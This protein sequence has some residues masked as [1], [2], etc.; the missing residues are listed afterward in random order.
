[1]KRDTLAFHRTFHRNFRHFSAIAATMLIRIRTNVGTWRIDLSSAG[2]DPRIVDLYHAIRA[3]HGEGLVFTTPLSKDPRGSGVMAEDGESSLSVDLG[4]RNGDM[5]HGRVDPETVASVGDGGAQSVT[6][7]GTDGNIHRRAATA[8]DLGRSFRPGMQALRDMKMQ[9]T[10]NDFMAM[11]D[12]FVF[13]IKRQDAADCPHVSMESGEANGFQS[14]LRE[15]GFQRGRMGYLYGRYEDAEDASEDKKKEKEGHAADDHKPPVAPGA[16]KV[17]VECIY[18]PPQSYDAESDTI[19]P[20]DDPDGDERVPILAAHLGLERVGWIF[21]H[22]PREEGFQLSSHEI[23]TAAELQLEAAGGLEKSTPFVTIKV[24]V[25]PDGNAVVDAFQV[26]RQCMEMVAE[27]ALDVHPTR[28]GYCKVVDTF[29]AVMEGKNSDEVEN[30]FFLAVVPIGRHVSDVYVQ[31]FPRANRDGQPQTH[32]AM[33]RQLSKS[34][35]RGWEFI[36]LLADFSLLL[37]LC[38]FQGVGSDIMQKICA[39]VINRKVPLDD[40][41]KIMLAGMAG[42]DGAY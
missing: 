4:L 1:L 8:D 19:D 18:E 11:D 3:E 2:T 14:Y 29:T 28:P 40:G 32:D 33:R 24:T 16:R 22:A 23:L 10:L 5:V 36:D 39:S 41:Y 31:Q 20:L 21:G 13:K 30:N 9:W 42:M 7:V 12:R 25:G 38:E 27:G 35:T 6:F 17:I 15:F 26:S 37:Y 34:G